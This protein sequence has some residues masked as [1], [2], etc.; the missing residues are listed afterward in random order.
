MQIKE[1]NL[2]EAD[3]MSMAQMAGNMPGLSVLKAAMEGS[4]LRSE[5]QDLQEAMEFAKVIPHSSEDGLPDESDAE[6]VDLA[7]GL[8]LKKSGKKNRSCPST[9]G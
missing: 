4:N 3:Q 2:V 1:L 6:G 5:A 8:R 9:D 7:P